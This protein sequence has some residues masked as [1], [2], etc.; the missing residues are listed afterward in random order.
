MLASYSLTFP[1][2]MLPWLQD[3]APLPPMR[4]AEPLNK[5]SVDFK[6]FAKNPEKQARY[7]RYLMLKRT[8]DRGK[9]VSPL[10]KTGALIG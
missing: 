2:S 10:L 4:S 8:G 7:E 1:F 3:E 9:I 6:P 5:Q